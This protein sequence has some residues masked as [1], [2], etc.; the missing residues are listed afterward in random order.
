MSPT[1][2]LAVPSPPTD[3]SPRVLGRPP[4]VYFVQTQRQQYC[5]E[6]PRQTQRWGRWVG[7]SVKRL[8]LGFSSGLTVQEFEPCAGLCAGKVEPA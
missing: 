2:R 3:Y 5:R 1:G 7:Q 6:K 8:T 4:V